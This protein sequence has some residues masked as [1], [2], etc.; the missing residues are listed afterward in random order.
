M[1]TAKYIKNVNW[2]GNAV[3]Y[4]LSEPHCGHSF[5][6]VSAVNN[7][8][9]HETFIFPANKKGGAIEML[10]MDGSR[11]NTISHDEVLNSI[12]YTIIT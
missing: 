2:Q 1:K 8:F 7:M 11:R 12:G 5:V 4:H 3:L 10:E 9:A 6:I